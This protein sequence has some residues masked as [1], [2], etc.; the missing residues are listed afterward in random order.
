MILRPVTRSR[1]TRI[2]TAIRTRT[3]RRRGTP[4]PAEI[5]AR[6]AVLRL[7]DVA[8][9]RLTLRRRL[10]VVAEG[11]VALGHL[12]SHAVAVRGLDPAHGVRRVAHQAVEDRA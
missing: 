2:A 12:G 9:V 6:T 7:D 5:A 4:H 8:R 10:A 3:K 1:T 11:G